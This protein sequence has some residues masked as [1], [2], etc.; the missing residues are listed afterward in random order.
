[1]PSE[2]RRRKEILSFM[3][4]FFRR[5]GDGTLGVLWRRW[6]RRGVVDD[7]VRR[8]RGGDGEVVTRWRG[9]G[10]VVMA[11]AS[12]WAIQPRRCDVV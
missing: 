8:W 2:P 7:A 5:G 4:I 9:G 11:V 12:A 3:S 6:L 1:M 10:E